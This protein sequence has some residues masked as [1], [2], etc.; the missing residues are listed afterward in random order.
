MLARRV[1]GWRAAGPTSLLVRY[2]ARNPRKLCV[3]KGG[4]R[5]G[6]EKGTEERKVESRKRKKKRENRRQHPPRTCR[7]TITTTRSSTS[8]TS[9]NGRGGGGW[10]GEERGRRRRTVDATKHGQR[11]VRVKYPEQ[12]NNNNSMEETREKP[13]SSIHIPLASSYDYEQEFAM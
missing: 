1:N 12:D 5:E 11:G 7:L 2:T 13:R 6:K 8:T 4:G 10:R 9:S 3:E